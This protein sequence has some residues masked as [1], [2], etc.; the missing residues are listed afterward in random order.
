VRARWHEGLV[1]VGTF[2]DPVRL[3][4]GEFTVGW[5]W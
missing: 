2:E 3:R 4:A 1:D 5:L